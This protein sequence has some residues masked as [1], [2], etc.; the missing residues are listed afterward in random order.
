MLRITTFTL[1]L[2]SLL[3]SA[4][5]SQDDSD[6]GG[7]VLKWTEAEQPPKGL[8]ND[9]FFLDE[10]NGWAVGAGGRVSRTTDGGRRWTEIKAPGK[11]QFWNGVCFLDAR[12]GFAAGGLPSPHEDFIPE[13]VVVTE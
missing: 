4:A 13:Q 1:A 9:A 2:F 8:A 10:K 5:A 7:G 11:D 6:R 12:R 3:L